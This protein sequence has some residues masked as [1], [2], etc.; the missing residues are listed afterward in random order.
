MRA[1]RVQ[2]DRQLYKQTIRSILEN[3]ANLKIFQQSVEDLM[4]E[5]D[6]IEGVITHIG[7]GSEQM[8]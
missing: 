7:Y 4:V 1:T 5:K 8:P 2:A 3:Q 6:E